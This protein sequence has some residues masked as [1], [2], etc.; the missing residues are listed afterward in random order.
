MFNLENIPS[1]PRAQ[2]II[3]VKFLINRDG[4]L[5]VSAFFPKHFMST[6]A[7]LNTQQPGRYP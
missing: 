5:E 1:M 7:V 6:W 2:P 3:N 4:V